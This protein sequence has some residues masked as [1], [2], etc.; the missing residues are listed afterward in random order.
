MMSLKSFYTGCEKLQY[1]TV[2]VLIYDKARQ[3]ISFAIE[4]RECVPLAK[5]PFTQIHRISYPPPDKLSANVFFSL[6]SSRIAMR[7]CG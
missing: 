7:L 2:G 3:I 6:V 1:K 5:K 4:S